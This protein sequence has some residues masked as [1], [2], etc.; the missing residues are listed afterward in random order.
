MCF[1]RQREYEEGSTSTLCKRCCARP[2][3]HAEERQL[4]VM[5]ENPK[6]YEGE[7][8]RPRLKVCRF[9]RDS[10][11]T[12]GNPYPSKRDVRETPGRSSMVS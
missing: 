12:F 6:T 3:S 1:Q 11:E 9:Q 8:G 10:K 4:T 5:S 7:V 2:S